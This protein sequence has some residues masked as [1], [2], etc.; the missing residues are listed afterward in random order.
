MT[1]KASLKLEVSERTMGEGRGVG[2]LR[3][4]GFKLFTT[5]LM[6]TAHYLRIGCVVQSIKGFDSYFGGLDSKCS[7]SG[8]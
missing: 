1:E 3:L 6:L 5:F 2:S 4:N 7:L 8:D